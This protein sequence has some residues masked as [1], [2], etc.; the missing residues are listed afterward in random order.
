MPYGQ[1]VQT[2]FSLAG[3]FIFVNR[4]G[5]GRGWIKALAVS[6]QAAILGRGVGSGSCQELAGIGV[7]S[8]IHCRDPRPW[9]A[10]EPTDTCLV[11]LGLAESISG[12]DEREMEGSLRADHER[13]ERVLGAEMGYL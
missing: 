11:W 10:C 4:A 5:L 8:G 12:R 6:P 3:S 2:G 1:S 7:Q 9:R 13:G